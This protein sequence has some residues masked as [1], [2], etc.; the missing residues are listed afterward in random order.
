VLEIG[1]QSYE[2]VGEIPVLGV[3]EMPV[4]ICTCDRFLI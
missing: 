2:G 3:G 1:T 4:L